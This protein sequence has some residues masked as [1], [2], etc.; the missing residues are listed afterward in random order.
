MLIQFDYDL[1]L[2]KRITMTLVSRAY[3]NSIR[4]RINAIHAV[5]EIIEREKNV[6]SDRINMI[7]ENDEWGFDTY[8]H[9]VALGNLTDQ[10]N[11]LELELD[12]L[13][14]KYKIELGTTY[15]P[16]PKLMF[17]AYTHPECM[18]REDEHQHV[19]EL[20]LF[21]GDWYGIAYDSTEEV[22][23]DSTVG[24]FASEDEARKAIAKE[25]DLIPESFK[26]IVIVV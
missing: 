18:R 15:F 4:A 14:E 25:W 7:K 23:D 9:R 10:Q 20:Q 1:V 8:D 13:I 24:P 26:N 22:K 16:A 11:I 21:Q 12:G 3:T 2:E 5:L 17:F 6:V 19:V